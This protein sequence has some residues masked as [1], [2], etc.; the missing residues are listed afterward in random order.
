VPIQV[1]CASCQSQF[2]APDNA[3]GKRTKCPKCGGIID[4]QAPAPKPA[5]APK[6][7]EVFEAEEVPY[8]PFTD[9]DFEVEKPAALPAS[10]EDRK[11]CPMCGEMIQKDAVKCR[12]CGEIFDPVLKKQEK[13]KGK[14]S[15]T[16]EDMSTGEW[17]VAIICSGIG[18]IAGIIWM[19]QGKPKGKKMLL[20]SIVANLFWS[21]V[22]IIVTS[23]AQPHR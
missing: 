6:E 15:A 10:T 9:D 19:I 1:T 4:I 7:E 16:D 13:K 17:V 21:A 14:S 20:V 11:P 5:P 23:L 8:T 2:N 18:C 3:A 22:K 12:F